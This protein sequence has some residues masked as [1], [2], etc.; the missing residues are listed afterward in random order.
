MSGNTNFCAL[1]DYL[2]GYVARKLDSTSRF[3][4]FYDAGTDFF[5]I[6]GAY[7]IFFT[8]NFYPAWLLFLIT[9]SFLQFII[10]SHY[11]KKFFDPIGRYLGSALYIGIALTLL[12]PNQ[13]VDFVQYAFV[14]FFLTSIASRVVSLTKRQN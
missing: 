10:T 13:S 8:Q 1:T 6:I 14:I 2:D 7:T 11:A 9:I 12:W 5:F 4:A 3:G